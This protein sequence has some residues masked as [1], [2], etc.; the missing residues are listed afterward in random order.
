MAIITVNT[1][2]D[3]NDA[4][5][6]GSTSLR[7]ALAQSVAGDTITFD[8]AIFNGTINLDMMLG[9]L[10][11]DKNLIIDGTDANITVD[12][13]GNSR[14]FNINDGNT[15]NVSNVTIEGLTITGG[16]FSGGNGGGIFNA[17][18]LNISN[19]TI[20][21]NLAT[22][23]TLGGGY[24]GGISGGT[25]AL[26]NSDVINNVAEYGGGVQTNQ[27]LAVINSTISGN[28]ANDRGGAIYVNG[29]LSVYNSDI[30]GNSA[31]DRAG[32]IYQGS[33]A[34]YVA[35]SS[36]SNNIAA[37]GG[38]VDI[39]TGSLAVDSTT[40][41]DNIA[42]SGNGGAIDNQYGILSVENS[43]ISGNSSNSS[44]GAIYN[45]DSTTTITNS[46]ISGNTAT[47]DG[48]IVGGNYGNNIISVTNSTISGNSSGTG[49]AVYSGYYTDGNTTT[50]TSTISIGNSIIAANVNNNDLDGVGTF[51]TDGNNLIGNGD[52]QTVFVDGTVGDIVGTALNP[53]DPLLGPLQDNGGPTFTQALDP[54]SSAVDAGADSLAGGLT[55]DQRGTTFDRIV[56]SAV[57]IGAFELRPTSLVVDTLIDENDGI[58]TG[59]VSLRDALDVIAEGG[60]ITFD[61]SIVSPGT[62]TI[63]LNATYGQLLVDKSVVIDGAN[64]GIIVDAGGSSR[65]FNIDDSDYNTFSNVTIDG[66]T[67][68]G[69]SSSIGGAIYNAEDLTIS[70][71]TISGNSATTRGGGIYSYDYSSV[72]VNNSTIA[73]NSANQDGGGI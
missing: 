4:I 7:E 36:I 49:A 66:L 29:T 69:G 43:T 65:V 11:I 42:S 10:S 55:N 54:N 51:I 40:I 18:N 44:G 15:A 41:A 25:I 22:A 23:D 19:S 56:D 63:S 70:N 37:S 58:A 39:A 59:E 14:V 27:S 1:L 26:Y 67:I 52:G 34:G 62:S 46:T 71:S 17:E 3:E 50:Y 28:T 8:T 6:N 48:A 73:D 61:S 72:T 13:Q 47:D 5:S 60:T 16:S 64:L 68:T 53:E 2:T 31:V 57:D 20:S 12:A 32:A 9:E 33:G 24:G 21:G 38:A 30:S 45:F 35:Y